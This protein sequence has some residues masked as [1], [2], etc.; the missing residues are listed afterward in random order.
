M[1]KSRTFIINKPYK[2]LYGKKWY[3]RLKSRPEDDE[4]QYM[5][6]LDEYPIDEMENKLV[7]GME[8]QNKKNNHSRLFSIFKDYI[9]LLNYVKL[10]PEN[11]RHFYEI[12][13]G[14][15]AQKPHFD[16]DIDDPAYTIED[17]SFILNDVLKSILKVLE[18][19]KIILD[20]NKDI[21][22]FNSHGEKKF[23]YHIV[24]H[25]WIHSNNIQAKGFYN[26]VKQECNDVSKKF[27][28]SSVYSKKQNFRLIGSQK[29]GSNRLKRFETSFNFRNKTIKHILDIDEHIKPEASDPSKLTKSQKEN[30]LAFRQAELF[31]ETLV[32]WIHR[33]NFLPN[34]VDEH[35]DHQ[36][37]FCKKYIIK[38]NSN[39]DN[40]SD[41][42][43]EINDSE[44][45]I[46]EEI[47]NHIEHIL[48]EKK[49][50]FEIREIENNIVALLR[51]Q[52]SY[53]ETCDRIHENENPYIILIDNILY[54]C[55]RRTNNMSVFLDLSETQYINHLTE[56]NSAK[57]KPLDINIVL[58]EEGVALTKGLNKVS[59]K[60]HKDEGVSLTKVSVNNND[61][62]ESV[63]TDKN[64]LE[65]IQSIS[66][67]TT[68]PKIY[69]NSY[70]E[71]MHNKNISLNTLF[72]LYSDLL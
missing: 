14:E 43:V 27:L 67:N 70:I 72:S 32:S 25:H 56:Y 42:Y 8:Q 11:N 45:M 23:S 13:F 44:A 54:F 16:L 7:V 58:K 3:Y 1:N 50:P 19:K 38:R 26:L 15:Y 53:C 36:K 39:E 66:Q 59:V 6:L 4:T 64:F 52:P 68:K 40:D 57:E 20:L 18:N 24:I 22:I 37:T 29:I 65:K 48:E 51:L 61:E 31:Q 49:Y 10:F 2:Y 9:D 5:C 28:D 55:C 33:C 46:S 60:E 21:L 30:L 47:I 69:K 12:I 71:E 41:E 34:F 63:P 35:K 17:A 62:E